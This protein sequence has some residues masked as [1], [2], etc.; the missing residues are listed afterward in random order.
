MGTGLILTGKIPTF[1]DF[2]PWQGLDRRH[3][4]LTI[5]VY[6]I[7][8]HM[9]P[10][11]L[12]SLHKKGRPQQAAFFSIPSPFRPADRLTSGSVSRHPDRPDRRRQDPRPRL[13][14]VP[15]GP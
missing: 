6:G 3:F 13:P 8:N 9:P 5:E 4:K 11:K 15:A 10:K 14:A 1:R 12:D 7:T 2:L